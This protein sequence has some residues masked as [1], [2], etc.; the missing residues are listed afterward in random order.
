MN[1]RLVRARAALRDLRFDGLLVWKL[2]NVRYLSGFTGTEGSL[3]ITEKE[4]LFLSDSRYTIQ[5]EEQVKPHGFRVITFKDKIKELGSTA[6]DLG[7]QSVGFEEEEISV[8]AHARL[9]KAFGGVKLAR[10]GQLVE[11]LRVVKDAHEIDLIREAVRVQEEAM[12]AILPLIAPGATENEIA[13]ALDTEM[14]RRGASGVSFDTI[15]GSGPR[16]AMPHGVAS[17]KKIA[18][19]ELVVLDWGCFCNG[20]CSDQTLT[21]CVGEPSDRDAR[22]VFAVVHEAQAASLAALRPGVALA[23]VDRAGRDIIRRAGYG[24][25]FGHGT[26]H[27]LGLEIHE[28]PRANMVSTAKAEPGLVITIEPGIYLP[29]RFGVR[30]EDIA[31]VTESGAE[32]LTTMHKNWRS[33][34]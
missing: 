4:A 30:L 11:R 18:A 25:Y 6:Q 13:F 1:S 19:G 29:G 31:L 33:T 26:G 12:E 23:E 9:A 5:A 34:G 28:E 10:A 16:G 2:V 22:K 32:P 7:V 3:L 17:D 27:S 14:R 8:A 15:V 24:D 20:Y 21:V